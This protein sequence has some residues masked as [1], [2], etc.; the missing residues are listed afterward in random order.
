MRLP[1]L[2]VQTRAA[3]ELLEIT[4]EVRAAVRRTGV[5]SGLVVVYVP[6]TTAGVTI[7]ENADPD[8]RTDLLLALENAVPARPARGTYRHAEGNSAAHVKA[9]LVGSSASII[10]DGGELLLGTWQG[11]Y[12][13]EFD[14]P[15]P[16]TVELKLLADVPLPLPPEPDHGG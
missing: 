15:R 12:L 6:H 2:T 4:G 3:H 16:R 5:A 13:C 14:G 10:V 7:Q 11:V 9:S 1:P 8:V